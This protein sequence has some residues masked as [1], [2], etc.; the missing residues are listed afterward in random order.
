MF[1]KMFLKIVL[2][3][4]MFVS[5][6]VSLEND[7]AY[8]LNSSTFYLLL[9]VVP[10]DKISVDWTLVNRCLSSP[11]FRNTGP[12]ATDETSQPENRFHL[13]NGLKSVLDVVNSL[14]YVPLKDAFFFIS[15]ILPHKSGY[16]LHDDAKSHMEHYAET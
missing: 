6:Y 8:E 7:D 10:H 4:N 9:P 5:E 1:Q 15:D 12:V 3:R 2:D 14:V 16:S 11:I 13:A